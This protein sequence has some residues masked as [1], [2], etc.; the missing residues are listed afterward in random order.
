[1]LSVWFLDGTLVTWLKKVDNHY[2]RQFEVHQVGGA[3]HK[4]FWVPAGKPEEFNEHLAI[5]ENGGITAY[6]RKTTQLT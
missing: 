1:M 6:I 3:H 5:L 2:C 4:E